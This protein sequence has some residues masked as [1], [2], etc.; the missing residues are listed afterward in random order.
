MKRVTISPTPGAIAPLLPVPTLRRVEKSEADLESFITP[1]YEASWIDERDL[2]HR[3]F[4]TK[5]L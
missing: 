4:A 2:D 5:P 1:S 3:Y